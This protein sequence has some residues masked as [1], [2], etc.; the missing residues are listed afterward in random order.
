M[1]RK[2][3]VLVDEGY[4][5][6]LTRGNDRRKL[7]RFRQDYQYFLEIIKRYLPKFKIS[8]L[9]YCLMPNHLHLLIYARRAQDLSKFMQAILQVYAGHF[10]K[11]YNS[12]GFVFENRY[13]SHLIDKEGYLLECSRYIERN[14]LRSKITDNLLNYTWSS[15]SVYAKGLANSI[16]KE[17][18]PLYLEYSEDKQ[19]RQEW[20]RKYVLE[21]RPYELIVDKEFKI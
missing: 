8:I 7:F 10:R 2:A 14:P 6:I 9:H 4:Y 11:K 13:K 20:Y 16:I 5:H 17:L 12:V 3:R 15:F 19:E 21:E 18:N 1:P